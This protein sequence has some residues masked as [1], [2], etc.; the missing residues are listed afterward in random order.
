MP[1]AAR[2]RAVFHLRPGAPDGRGS[3][4]G[5][6]KRIGP[7]PPSRTFAPYAGANVPL[8][9]L[10][11]IAMAGTGGRVASEPSDF[12]P[13]GWGKVHSV[14]GVREKRCFPRGGSAPARGTEPAPALSLTPTLEPQP[15]AAV[16]V[17]GPSPRRGSRSRSVLVLAEWLGGYAAGRMISPQAHCDRNALRK[18]EAVCSSMPT[19]GIT[20]VVSSAA[21]Y[22]RSAG[23]SPASAAAASSYSM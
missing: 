12:S 1:R 11:R 9:R 3:A 4:R 13:G 18:R 16:A 15:P 7:T 5:S 6:E 14:R 21:R 8:G 23:A 22:G 19:V 20:T 10:S 2:T 17:S